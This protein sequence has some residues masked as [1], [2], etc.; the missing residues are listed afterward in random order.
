MN[1]LG[2]KV[3]VDRQGTSLA[4]WTRYSVAILAVNG[5]VLGAGT[6]Y[7]FWSATGSGAGTAAVGSASPMTVVVTGLTGLYPTQKTTVP[8]AVTN[9]NSYAVA[10]SSIVLTTVTPTGGGCAAGDITLDSTAGG[11][12]GTTYS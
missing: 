1:I 3:T 9:T 11:V 5:V 6:A 12:S 2:L 7:A 4:K 8:V 10:L